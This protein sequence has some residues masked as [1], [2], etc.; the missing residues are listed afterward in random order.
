MG[1]KDD[2]DMWSATDKRG[3]NCWLFITELDNSNIALTIR[4]NDYAW[5][6]ICGGE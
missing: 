1:H 3:N 5:M 4:Y 6:Y 2:T